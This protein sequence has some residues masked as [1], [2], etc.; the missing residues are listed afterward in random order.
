MCRCNFYLEHMLMRGFKILLL[1]MILP[2]CDL[3]SIV[4]ILLQNYYHPWSMY[5]TSEYVGCLFNKS[6]CSFLVEPMQCAVMN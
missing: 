5:A 1:P 3:S 2:S 4:E 6:L